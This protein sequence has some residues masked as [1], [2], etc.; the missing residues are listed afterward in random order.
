M[1][2]TK[3]KKIKRHE[4]RRI[5]D[6]KKQY[7]LDQQSKLLDVGKIIASEINLTKLFQIINEQTK[8]LIR[9][10][11][12]TVFLHDEKK[13]MLWSLVGTKMN[14]NEI[15][16]SDETGAASWTFQN[17]EALIINDPYKDQ[18]FYSEIDKKSGFKTKNILCVP[19]I[20]RNKK[21]IGAIQAL[22]KNN[23]S[24]TDEDKETLFSLSRYVVIALE[25]S[26]LYED[27]KEAHLKLEDYSKDLEGLVEQR[28]KKLKETQAKLLESEKRHLEHQITGGFAHEMRNALTGGMLE[29]MRIIKYEND[30]SAVNLIEG[31]AADII[32][33]I[34][35]LEKK[36]SIPK[37]MM[38]DNLIPII[39]KMHNLLLLF[40]KTIHNVK[41]DIGR[42]LAT[43]NQI[44]DYSKM[45]EIK[46]GDRPVDVKEIIKRLE[47]TYATRMAES[48]IDYSVN[49]EGDNFVIKGDV[50]Q[51]ES[52]VK[53]ILLNAI[54]AVEESKQKSI[55]LLLSKGNNVDTSYIRLVVED[56]GHGIHD[57]DLNKLFDP[58]FTK[59]YFKGTGLG[60][61]I[62]KRLVG[63]YEGNIS[64]ESEVGEG[65][66]FYVDLKIK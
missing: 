44:L 48:N 16:L 42:G 8:Q 7:L 22:N 46:R 63:L 17:K 25:N 31:Y 52:I 64:V 19:L 41:N 20:H 50:T 62:V 18:R 14:R 26:K 56:S 51:V 43:T 58:F 21:C 27:L 15:R 66:K 40:D 36:Y 32:E 60:L 37:E 10:E 47:D 1:S 5:E 65:T 29:L 53:N 13:G 24:F 45:Q 57:S 30:N 49:I 4:F 33:F 35:D 11:R 12:C 6:Q 38:N 39:K 59:K 34:S 9:S 23:S 61:S 55:N 3:N 28:T 54:D 2:L